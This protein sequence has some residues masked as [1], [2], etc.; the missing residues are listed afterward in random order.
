MVLCLNK[1][2]QMKI[3]LGTLYSNKT[4]KYLVPALNFYGPTLKSKINLIFKLS[5]GIFDTLLEGT[6]L[7]GQKNI[8]ILIDKK[9]KPDSY[10][11]F[12]QWIKLQE[13]YVT[14]YAFDELEEGRQHML[15][16]AF[17]PELGDA[18]TKFLE[19]KYSK[20]YTKDE[21]ENYFEGRIEAKKVFSRHPDAKNN[22]VSTIRK[23]FNT[24]LIEA[25]FKTEIFEYDLPPVKEEE[26]FNY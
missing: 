23:T 12:M 18:Y 10:D 24:S 17:P 15:V 16:L 5:F 21:I 14:D 1:K 13:Y 19:G 8:Y 6:Y 3:Q 11:N 7:E 25:D 2:S 22:F 9:V 4:L 20:M 26:F